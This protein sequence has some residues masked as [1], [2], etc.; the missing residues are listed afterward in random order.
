MSRAATFAGCWCMFRE[1]VSAAHQPR[2]PVAFTA[3]VHSFRLSTPLPVVFLTM[4]TLVDDA[5]IRA[6]TTPECRRSIDSTNQ[7]RQRWR[8]D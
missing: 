1:K 8:L 4:H 7:K 2:Y 3:S 5:F 6:A